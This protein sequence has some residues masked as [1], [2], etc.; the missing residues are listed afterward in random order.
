MIKGGYT[1]RLLR[2]NLTTKSTAT[3]ILEED[4]LRK[5]YGGRALAG[6]IL[7][8]EVDPR[9]DPLS[10]GN[11]VIFATGPFT[12][13]I[14][15]GS[16]RYVIVTKSPETGLY[17]DSYSGGHFAAEMKFAGYD[18]FVIEGKADKPVYI[19]IDNDNVEIRDAS[20]LWGKTTWETETQLLDEVGDHSAKAAVIGPAGERLSNLAI[21]QNEYYHQC[22][23]GGVGAVLGSKNLKAVVVRGS[24][25][26]KIADPQKLIN[27]LLTNVEA[28]FHSE[29]G[30][31]GAIADRMKYGTPLT[32]NITNEVGILPT[33]NFKYGQFEGADEINGHAFRR[34]VVISDKGCYAC[35][36]CCTKF[37][38]VKSGKYKGDVIGGPEYETNALIGANLGIDSMEF[39]VHANGI[40][41]NLGIDTIGAGNVIGFAMECY[42]KGLLTKEDLDGIELTFGNEE[43]VEKM[44]YKIAYRE[45]I[46]DLLSQGVKIASETIGKGSEEFAMHVKGLEFPAYR[47]GPNSPGFGLAYCIADRGACH[48]RAWPSIAEQSLEPYTTKGRAELVKFLYDQRI[49][50]HC[51]LNCDIAVLVPNL[52]NTDAANM[53]RYV[54]GWDV[55]EQEMQQLSERTATLLRAYN[56]REGMKRE[57]ETLPKRSFEVELTE[58]GRGLKLTKEMLDE[59]LSE[60]YQ[61]R[62][63]DQQGVPTY[64]TLKNLGLED[65]AQDL[66]MNGFLP[67]GGSKNE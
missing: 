2:V 25:D 51:G 26:F 31:L 21:V 15:P 19:W 13:S 28:K 49:P 8:D 5:Y 43:A 37:S 46:G 41:D 12:G 56:I 24:K 3:E 45:G 44:L 18:M 60:Y 65:I 30:K 33:K 63:W 67:R 54:I 52:N 7:Y 10:E 22:G 66:V 20:H 58:K 39:I 36:L 23:R 34:K 62:G 14:V 17:L 35:N 48:R 16:N 47:P 27:Y 59:M 11:K 29:G 6:R 61:L 40:C 64:A 42:E 1:R 55:D 38:S 57:D 32:L 50:W 9:T 53:Y 4:F